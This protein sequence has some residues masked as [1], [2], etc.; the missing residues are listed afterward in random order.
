M[1]LINFGATYILDGKTKPNKLTI[2]AYSLS[3]AIHMAYDKIA[4]K[5]G[6]S[7][8]ALLESFKVDEIK[9]PPHSFG[10]T[11]PTPSGT[12]KSRTAR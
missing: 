4:K 2:K 9:G 5:H 10:C 1:K 12:L 8:I 7:S 3:E 11:K 6:E